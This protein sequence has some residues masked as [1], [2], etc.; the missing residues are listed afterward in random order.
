[1][2]SDFFPHQ[3]RNI[4]Y[5]IYFLAIPVGGAMG[6]AI[7]SVLGGQFGWRVA[8][9][10]VGL[11]GVA[12]AICVLLIN[13]PVVGINDKD[14]LAAA[15]V[16]P[17][18]A[19]AD[20]TSAVRSPLS[21]GGAENETIV[22][23]EGSDS[24]RS[25]SGDELSAI[26][27]KS[28]SSSSSEPS[29]EDSSETDWTRLRQELRIILYNKY[30]ACA[31]GGAIANNFALGGLAEW[32]PSFLVRYNDISISEAGLYVGAATVL[33]GI[34][35]NL[36]GAKSA[37]YFDRRKMHNSYLIVSA[38]YTAPAAFFFLLLINSTGSTILAI[39]FLFLA[40]IC[41]W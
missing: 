37:Q 40:E 28:S 35:G 1:M 18:P 4:A 32:I 41:V 6:F 7:G 17:S 24:D 30:F 31:L 38:A 13:N 27:K 21:A 12:A 23:G 8:F 15:G 26:V 14:K 22:T 20:Q 10:G 36:L 29:G 39:T 11:P 9:L 19:P 5:A 16:V 34:G 2:I 33:G 25:T 3:D